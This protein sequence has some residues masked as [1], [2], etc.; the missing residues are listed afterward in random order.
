MLFRAAAMLPIVAVGLRA[1]GM[2]RMQAALA[3]LSSRATCRAASDATQAKEIARLVS[4]AA[5][6]GPYRA[7]CLP[8]ALALQWLLRRH[9]LDAELR[10]GV[11]KKDGRVEAHAWIEHQGIPLI[12]SAD[13]GERFRAFDGAVD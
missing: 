4:I 6:H 2:R 7:R 3:K 11:R 13:M 8:V 12:D 5:R 10:L 9:G 1:I